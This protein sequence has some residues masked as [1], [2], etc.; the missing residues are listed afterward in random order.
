MWDIL[1]LPRVWHWAT[2]DM[3]GDM[4]SQGKAFQGASM[5]ATW[6]S[7]ILE[8][9]YQ[10]YCLGR[11]WALFTICIGW[12]YRCFWK[13][14]VYC[15]NLCR[16]ILAVEIKCIP[17]NRGCTNEWRVCKKLA[18]RKKSL[19]VLCS[20]MHVVPQVAEQVWQTR[21]NFCCL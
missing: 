8:G 4:Q 21:T 6:P 17:W 2:F 19:W 13:K 12:W 11:D 15:N 1:L 20:I 16:F 18:I 3:R 14:G 9:F 10:N 7:I 5:D